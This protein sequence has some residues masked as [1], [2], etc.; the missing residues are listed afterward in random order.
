MITYTDNTT[1]TTTAVCVTGSKGD[2]GATGPQGPQGPQG[3]KGDKGPQGDKGATGATGPQGP[4]GAAGKDANQ[5]VH[6]VNGNGESNLYV[7][8]ATIKI[9][10]WYANHPTTF[11]LA[12]RGFETTDVQFSFIS[13][14]NSD[15]G[16]DFLRS[17][18]GW[19]LWIYKKDYFNV[20]PYNKIK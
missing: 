11:K 20:G 12:G 18:G 16:L 8:F 13:A 6:T 17:S 5:V 15:P 9:T 7:E 10:G 14:N 19:S 1:S 4:Q 3:V 2:K